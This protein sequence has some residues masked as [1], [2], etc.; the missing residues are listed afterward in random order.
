MAFGDKDEI[1]ENKFQ[2]SFERVFVAV[3]GSRVRLAASLLPAT[4][5]RIDV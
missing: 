5:L 1:V 2:C 3:A 4:S